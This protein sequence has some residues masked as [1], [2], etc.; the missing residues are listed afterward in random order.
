MNTH[1]VIKEAE[2]DVNTLELLDLP[3]VD[4]NIVVKPN[5]YMGYYNLEVIY[6]EY[7]P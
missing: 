3:D 6:G 5:G 2:G 7:I 1:T 4:Y